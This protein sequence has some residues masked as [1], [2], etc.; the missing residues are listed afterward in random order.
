MRLANADK[1]S[2]RFSP[3]AEQYDQVD[4]RIE[5]TAGT[6]ERLTLHRQNNEVLASG[7]GLLL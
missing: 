6:L 2:F 1:L 5:D 3:L 7:K 4:A